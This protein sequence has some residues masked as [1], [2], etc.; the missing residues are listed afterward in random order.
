MI[1]ATIVACEIGF[2]VFLLAGLSA[3]YVLRRPRL[4]LI[5]LAI[6]PLVDVVLL[7]V[8][9][10]DLR[11]GGQA[12]FAHTLS[13]YYIGISV[14][15]GHTLVAWADRKFARRFGR[16]G[17]SPTKSKPRRLYGREHIREQW[18]GTVQVWVAAL[19]SAGI[20]AG[21]VWMVGQ[22]E[23]TKALSDGLRPIGVVVMID[24]IITVSYTIWP[25]RAPSANSQHALD[26]LPREPSQPSSPSTENSAGPEHST[27]ER[28][29]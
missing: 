18:K 29:R 17:D 3:R 6:A 8:T 25:R 4:G 15:F 5:L 23:Q 7:S 10:A 26:G 27:A 28:I 2:W 20:L 19:I 16:E 21:M 9:V 14:A 22:P 24:L 11:G 1:V 12:S 13:A